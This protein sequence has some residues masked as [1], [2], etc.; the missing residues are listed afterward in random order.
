MLVRHLA[1]FSGGAVPGAGQA[2]AV[3]VRA[4]IPAIALGGGF[5]QRH[6]AGHQQYSSQKSHTS[7][8]QWFLPG[9]DRTS[10]TTI[11]LRYQFVH[12]NPVNCWFSVAIADKY[13]ELAV[14]GKGGGDQGWVAGAVFGQGELAAGG[15]DQ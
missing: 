7:V 4:T 13:H 15:A 3:I 5:G 12:S 14:G 8:F 10:L 6:N 9:P 1:R 11:G 2:G